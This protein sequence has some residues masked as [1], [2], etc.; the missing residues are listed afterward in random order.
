VRVRCACERDGMK[1][2]RECTFNA[3]LDLATLLRTRGREFPLATLGDRKVS[4]LRIAS[5][6]GHV[7]ATGDA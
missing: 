4:G 7:C 1:S 6:V 5:C 2:I 3:R